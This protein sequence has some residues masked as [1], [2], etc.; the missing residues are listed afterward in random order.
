MD[1]EEI[2]NEKSDDLIQK[3]NNISK[4]EIKNYIIAIVLFLCSLNI[5]LGAII[6]LITKDKSKSK[7]D[8]YDFYNKC[9]LVGLLLGLS[10]SLIYVVY[11]AYILLM[12]FTIWFRC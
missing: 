5:I 8:V 7:H 10:I 1:N 4:R 9:S 12:F 6:F 11:V 2:K 3:D